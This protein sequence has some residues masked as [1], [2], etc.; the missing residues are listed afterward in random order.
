MLLVVVLFATSG[1]D[2]PQGLGLRPA[3]P[4]DVERLDEPGRLRLADYQGI[5]VVV[6]FWAS[7][8]TPCRQEMPELDAL[9][10][11]HGPRIA[12]IGVNM[13]DRPEDARALLDELGVD[14]PVGIDTD[15]AAVLAYE[16]TVVPSTLFITADGRFAGRASGK[17]SPAELDDLIQRHFGLT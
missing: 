9:A 12:V 15:S 5:P 7:W 3:P 1:R 11:K 16:V 14:Y 17:P 13:Q 10:K 4:I 2:E 8:C 6:N